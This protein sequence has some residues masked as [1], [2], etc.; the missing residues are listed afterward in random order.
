RKLTVVYDLPSSPAAGVTVSQSGGSTAVTEGGATDT[1]T[2]A[3]NSAPMAN[4]T[5]TINGTAD[6]AGT[7]TALTFTSSN[8]QT[9]Q[10]VTL[11]AVDDDLVE[12]TETSNL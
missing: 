12:P 10:T 8:W 4:V 6:V 7:P 5:I 1:F 9:P 2:V 3:L 11:T